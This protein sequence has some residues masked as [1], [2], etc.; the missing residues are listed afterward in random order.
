MKI[1]KG[2]IEYT[3]S[4]RSDY[5]CVSYSAGKLVVEYKVPKAECETFEELE[6]RILTSDEFGG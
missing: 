6:H 4:E 1:T 5:W 2:T 3:V